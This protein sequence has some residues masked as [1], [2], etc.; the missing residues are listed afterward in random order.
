[1]NYNPSY[2]DEN[3]ILSSKEIEN[4]RKQN[5]ILNKEISDTLSQ[6]EKKR[7]VIGDGIF[8]YEG[9]LKSKIKILWIMKEPYDTSGG[10]WH[11]SDIFK[12]KQF[13]NA[14]TTWYPIINASHAIL[15]GFNTWDKRE[16][17]SKSNL[18]TSDVLSHIAYMNVQKLPS[19]TREKTN[20]SE[21]HKAFNDKVNNDFFKR[22][23][24]LLN[25]DIIIG[26]NTLWMM[27]LH[28][29][30]KGESLKSNPTENSYIVNDKLF[31][32]AKHPG[33]RGNGET[34]INNIITA[35]KGWTASRKNKQE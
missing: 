32:N 12:N 28:F 31:I 25:P 22:Q 33:N 4:F 2:V 27:F 9:Y 29:G 18:T 11:I 8:D 5:I 10:G 34:Y 14:R 6:P 7:F 3:I 1:M 24:E 23:F 21:I 15:K 16:S 17:V 13:G 30:L 35:T 19:L 20:N 26:A